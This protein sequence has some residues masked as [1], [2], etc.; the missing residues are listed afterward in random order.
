MFMH[1]LSLGP[2]LQPDLQHQT[3]M[4]MGSM[5][6]NTFLTAM[7]KLKMPEMR[8]LCD[9]CKVPVECRYHPVTKDMI[10]SQFAE[11]VSKQVANPPSAPPTL[12]H[13]RPSG[14]SV[15]SRPFTVALFS[16]KAPQRSVV[17]VPVHFESQNLSSLPPSLCHRNL[18][19]KGHCKL[20]LPLLRPNSSYIPGPSRQNPWLQECVQRC[21][22]YICGPDLLHRRGH[23]MASPEICIGFME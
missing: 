8:E 20:P 15:K 9:A 22:A 19:S 12:L 13:G 3:N 18:Q 23:C 14:V 4:A 21:S 16:T 17:L 11:R 2:C 5:S 10:V 1:C 7:Y 6:V